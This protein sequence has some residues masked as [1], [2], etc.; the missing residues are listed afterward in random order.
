MLDYEFRIMRSF[1]AMLSRRILFLLISC[2]LLLQ[3]CFYQHRGLDGTEADSVAVD[4]VEF[5]EEHHYSVGFN[6]VV[7]VDS[8]ALCTEIPSRAQQLAFMPDSVSV[9]LDEDLVV[10]E[11]QIVPE[12]ELDTVWVKVARDQVTQGWLRESQLLDSISP[13]DPISSAIYFFSGTHMWGTVALVLLL[14]LIVFVQMMRNKREKGLLTSR[15]L[16]YSPYPVLLY[17]SMGGSAVFYASLQLFAP[18]AWTE[19]YF[20]PTL[21]PFAVEPLLGAFLFSFWLMVLF[22]MATIDDAFRQ[23]RASHALLYLLSV[24]TALAVLYIFFSL[25]TLVFVGYPLFVLFAVLLTYLYFRYLSPRY[26]CGH[27]GRPFHT[28]GH[29]PHCGTLNE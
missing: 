1:R 21:N 10:A 17:L 13:D 7:K 19:F 22:F 15:M 27:C 29:C 12:D 3:S 25:S 11:I 8:L 24:V 16:I 28:K 18:N 6:F 5:A 2:M 4:S 14:G 9:Y 20:H 23:L 26:R